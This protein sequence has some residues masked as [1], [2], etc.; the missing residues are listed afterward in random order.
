VRELSNTIERALL[1]HRGPEITPSDLRLD[2]D[3][4]MVR[5]LPTD[6]ESAERQLILEA[7]RIEAGNRTRAARRLGISLRTLRNKLRSYGVPAGL[8]GVKR[9]A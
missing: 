3:L 8:P 2:E 7:L 6:L 9:A 1:F 5:R 4:P